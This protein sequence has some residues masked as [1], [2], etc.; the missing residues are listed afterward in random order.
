MKISTT[1]GA[2]NPFPTFITIDRDEFEIVSELSWWYSYLSGVIGQA[3][4]CTEA[5]TAGTELAWKA[6]HE[7]LPILTYKGISLVKRG[8]VF[9]ACVRSV[10]LYGS[11]T[12]PCLQKTC[13]E[14][15]DMLKQC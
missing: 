12:W 15:Q 11:E 13:H 1:T 7:P 6:F 9:K 3:G 2:V 10:L 4:D 8:K 5:V 14:V